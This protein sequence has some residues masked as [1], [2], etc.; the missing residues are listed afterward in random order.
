MSERAM[1]K[2]I[3]PMNKYWFMRIG[4]EQ[5]NLRNAFNWFAANNEIQKCVRLTIALKNFWRNLGFQKEGLRWT[6]FALERE[7]EIQKTLLAKGLLVAAEYCMDLYQSDR[8][9]VLLIKALDISKQ[10]SD[11]LLIGWCYAF[12]SISMLEFEHD[13]SEAIEKGQESL[14]IFHREDDIEGKIF[15]Y[16]LLGEMSRA[17]GNFENAKGYYEQSLKLTE[18]N[19][20]M[21]RKGSLY[22]NL[23]ILAYQRGDYQQA[24]QL[25]KMSLRISFDMDIYYGIFYDIG[26]L[27][28]GALGMGK[29]KR[30]AKLLGMSSAGLESFESFHQHTD[31]VVIKK[32]LEETRKNL[33]EKAFME[34]WEEGRKMTVQEA[35]EYALS[36]SV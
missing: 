32:I 31:Q 16:N 21:W 24:E 33:D 36:N 28:G 14:S 20:V 8:A 27:A 25:T 11:N 6:E 1:R 9:K 10:H 17:A 34:A 35:F 15:A 2:Y 12:Q 22:G 23:G 4:I 7:D 3:S 5:E 29:P 18:E 30:T 13:I 26:G 19:G